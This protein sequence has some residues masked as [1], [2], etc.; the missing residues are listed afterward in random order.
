[1]GIIYSVINKDDDYDIIDVNVE[2]IEHK[3]RHAF[4]I[5]IPEDNI[6]PR[7]IHD[8]KDYGF[9]VLNKNN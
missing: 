1:M 6:S 8:G 4:D 5:P 7:S 9:N 2:Y 3:H